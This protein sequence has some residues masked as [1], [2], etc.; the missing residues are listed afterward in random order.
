MPVN[1]FIS[2]YFTKDK[3]IA[4]IKI[5]PTPKALIVYTFL[6]WCSK[7]F[8]LKIDA[9]IVRSKT[10]GAVRRE[11]A[12]EIVRLVKKAV[13]RESAAI[14]EKKLVKRSGFN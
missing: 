4:P 3:L 5:I 11:I 13:K 1:I 10:N 7:R 14:V 2:H 9:M 12:E 8:G 6:V